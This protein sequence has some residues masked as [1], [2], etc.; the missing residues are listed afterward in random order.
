LTAQQ[1]D[2][3]TSYCHLQSCWHVNL[4]TWVVVVMGVA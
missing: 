3:P 2:L 4:T 1:H